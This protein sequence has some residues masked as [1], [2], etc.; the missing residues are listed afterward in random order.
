MSSTDSR[1]SILSKWTARF[2]HILTAANR[3]RSNVDM[4][5]FGVALGMTQLRPESATWTS[6]AVAFEMQ[7]R[8]LVAV[9]SQR[10]TKWRCKATLKRG[11]QN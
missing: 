2:V 8:F 1:E 6:I 5:W 3:D 9:N 7:V 10:T 4:I 11:F